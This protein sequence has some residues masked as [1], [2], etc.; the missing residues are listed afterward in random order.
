MQEMGFGWGW[1]M[2]SRLG[3]GGGGF[4]EVGN[5]ITASAGALSLGRIVKFIKNLCLFF[6]KEKF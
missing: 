1:G 6:S 3:S 4:D 5:A 2:R